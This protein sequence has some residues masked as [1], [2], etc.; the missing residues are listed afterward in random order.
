MSGKRKGVSIDLFFFLSFDLERDLTHPSLPHSF[1]L[2]VPPVSSSQRHNSRRPHHHVRPDDLEV[3]DPLHG[4]RVAG[5][6]FIFRLKKDNNEKEP[7]TRNSPR[8]FCFLSLSLESQVVVVLSGSMEPGFH[9]GDILFLSSA[10]KG[11][12]LSSGDIVV[13][14]I[15]GR[16]KK[17]KS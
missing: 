8:S 17:E 2:S 11:P 10:Q 16:G 4:L 1:S 3:P 12:P 9:R 6:F 14:N 13:F 7:G 15:G 5:E